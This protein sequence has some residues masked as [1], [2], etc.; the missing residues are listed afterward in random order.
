[1]HVI[2]KDYIYIYIYG[3]LSVKENTEKELPHQR[4]ER[5]VKK[6]PCGEENRKERE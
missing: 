6:E 5:A 4:K 3:V 1:M 2:Y